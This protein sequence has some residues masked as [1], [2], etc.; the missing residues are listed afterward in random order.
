MASVGCIC[1]SGADVCVLWIMMAL[2]VIYA[3][4]I[5]NID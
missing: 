4:L 5:M 1:I 3:A 2:Y